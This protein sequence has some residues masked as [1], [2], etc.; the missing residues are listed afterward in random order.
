MRAEIDRRIENYDFAHAALGLYEFV[1]GELCD[2]YLEL[3]KPRLRAGES[4]LGATLLYVL[5]QTLAIAHPMIPFVTEEIYRYVPGASGLLA[6]GLPTAPT[7]PVDER[8]EASVGRV[9]EAVQAMRG[10]RDFAGVKA[11]ATV[12]ARLAAEGYEGTEEHLAR[13]ARLSFTAD[14]AEPVASVPV[15]GGAIEILPS[16]DVDVEGAQRRLAARRAKLE[17]EIERAERKLGNQGFVDKAP[18]DVVQAERDKLKRLKDELDKSLRHSLARLP[19]GQSRETIVTPEEAERYILSRELFGMR[20][21][22]DRMRRLMTAMGNPQLRFQSIHV[23]GTNGKSSTVRMTAAIL[24]RHGLRTG[25]YLSPHLVSFAERIRIEDEDLE[26]AEFAG[27]IQ[28][29]AHAAE[30]VDRSLGPDD[31]V[32]QFEFLTAAAYSELARQGVEVAVIEAGLGGRYDATN[33]IPSRVQVLTSVGLEHT[34]WLGPTITA[35]ATEKLDVVQPGATLVLGYGLHP[36]AVAV[37]ERVAGNRHPPARIVHAG[38]DPGVPLTALGPYQRRNFALARTAAEAYLGELDP[39]A[40]AT[41]AAETLVP[42]R[43]QVVDEEPLTLLDGAHNPEG[44]AALAESLAEPFAAGRKPVVA[45]IS[46]LDDKDAAGML[47]TLMPM[48]DAL[49]LTA[50]QNPR[51]LPPPTLQSLAGQLGGPPSEVIRDPRAAVARGRELAGPDGLV[52]AT[53]SIYLVADL[54][55]P[56]GAG[57]ASML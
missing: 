10:W 15:P 9:I 22:L 3:V 21:G 1:Y 44:I 40:V 54:L 39:N 33:V 35:I 41:A 7:A 2:W 14:G 16:D 27:A 52:V 50:S 29:A 56:A 55:R 12:P 23:V 11:A 32:T 25:A 45:V 34:R 49:V 8:A 48:C 42:G 20:F 6:A 13:L 18:P 19:W 5:T 51:A 37:A 47:A 46:I 53:G 57:R 36:D 31:R 38:A 43:L 4:E 24:R 26:P 30:L 17:E 28:R